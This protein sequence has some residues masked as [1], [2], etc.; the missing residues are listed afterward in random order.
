M[1]AGTVPQVRREGEI[2]QFSVSLDLVDGYEFAADFGLPQVEPMKLDESPPLGRGSGPDPARLLATA[3]ANCLASS[4]LFCLRKA[5]I[6][7]TGME[8]AAT[9]TLARNEQGRLRVTGIDVTLKPSVAPA[10]VAHM[11]RCIDIFEDFCPVT[12]AVRKGVAVMVEVQPVAVNGLP[13]AQR[14]NG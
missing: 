2:R 9:G 12:A 1:V 11:G 8:V 5:H 4:L 6:D 10:D 14:T 13:A 7:V 3:V